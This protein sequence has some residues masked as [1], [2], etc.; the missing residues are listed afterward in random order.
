M[1]KRATIKDVAA[2]AGVSLK[3]VSRVINREAGV[4]PA[5]AERV[6]RAVVQLD[7]RH[8]LAASNLRRGHRTSSIGVL[9]HDI[10][11]SFSATLLRAVEDRA[12]PRGIAVFSASLDD[13]AEREALLATDLVSRRVDGLI[14]MPTSPSQGYLVSDVLA[15]LAVVAVDRP[16]KGA[17]VDTVVV[18]NLE[19]AAAATRHLAGHGHERIA[20]L[21]DLTSIWT[22]A[23]RYEGYLRGLA[24]S[25]VPFDAELVVTDV[26]TSEDA[27]AVVHRLLA[28]ADP[29]TAIFAAR[30]NLGIGAVRALRQLN[31]ADTV[32]LVAFDDF[33]MADLVTPAITVVQQDITEVGRVAAELLFAQLDGEGGP[34]QK[35]V[36]PTTLVPRG[37]GEIPPQSLADAG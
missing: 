33:P 14:L 26:R 25:R 5:M 23:Q 29:P 9:L 28:L 12:R 22:A 2:L 21:T 36:L 8:N 7:Y 4:S 11:N 37:S 6:Q 24:A 15:G 16:V 30:N 3:T 20:L 17:D 34:P 1:R 10:G 32:A 18:D 27:T 35:V 31:L 19:G 13:E